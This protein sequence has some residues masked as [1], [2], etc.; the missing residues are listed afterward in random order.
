MRWLSSDPSAT[1][2]LCFALNLSCAATASAET[3]ENRGIGFGEGGL[4]AGKVDGFRGAAGRVG[5]GIEIKHELP[6]REVGQ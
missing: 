5:L 1:V 2:S 4:E 6:A 3:P